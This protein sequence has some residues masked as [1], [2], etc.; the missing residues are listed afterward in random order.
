[1]ALQI[2]AGILLPRKRE[3]RYKD[4]DPQI[5]VTKTLRPICDEFF[6]EENFFEDDEKITVRVVHFDGIEH[7]LYGIDYEIRWLFKQL[8]HDNNDNRKVLQTLIDLASINSNITNIISELGEMAYSQRYGQYKNK[9]HMLDAKQYNKQYNKRYNGQYNINCKKY[10]KTI[11][12][13]L[14]SKALT[15]MYRLEDTETINSLKDFILFRFI[16]ISMLLKPNPH[17]CV[18][19]II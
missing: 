3:I 5:N 9:Y 16:I 1:M 19:T 7:L 17:K 6:K 12:D 11:S 18:L 10:M 2:K 13:N 14:R 4:S 15:L 8:Q